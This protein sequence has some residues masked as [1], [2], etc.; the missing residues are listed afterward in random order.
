M[1]RQVAPGLGHLPEHDLMVGLGRPCGQPAT[2]LSTEVIFG[3]FLH[4]GCP[5]EKATHLTTESSWMKSVMGVL[6]RLA[7]PNGKPW[8]TYAPMERCQMACTSDAARTRSAAMPPSPATGGPSP[9]VPYEWAF[10]AARGRNHL[11]TQAWSTVLAPWFAF[12]IVQ[13]RWFP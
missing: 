1:L 5:E 11:L 4:C 10:L 13:R 8:N 6:A 9:S 12:E 2:L 3:S 7:R